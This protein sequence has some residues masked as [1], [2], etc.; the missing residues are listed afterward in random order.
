[1][2][3]RKST[4]KKWFADLLGK[5]VSELPALLKE[6]SNKIGDAGKISVIKQE[7][8]ELQLKKDI[9]LRDIE[10]L[11][12]IKEEKLN[13]QHQKTELELKSQF[14]DKEVALQ[15]KYHD[16]TLKLLDDAKKDMTGMYKEIMKRLPNVNARIEIKD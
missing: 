9:E 2:F 13:I 3:M 14:K 11:V 5:D 8:A 16:K 4:V 7:L 1:M 15:T 12:K 10:H 6:V